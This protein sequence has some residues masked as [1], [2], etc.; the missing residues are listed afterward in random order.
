MGL[1]M[2]ERDHWESVYRSKAATEVSW[3]RPKLERSLALIASCGLGADARI[4]DVGGGASTL[5]DDLLVLGHTQLTVVDLS[6]EALEVS[7]RRL[8]GAANAV[9]WRADDVTQMSFEPG[10]IALWHDR[11]VFHFLVDE[12][13]RTAYVAQTLRAVRPGGHVLLG[14]FAPDGP[15]RCSGLP[16]VR[17]DADGLARIFEA[18]FAL[19]ASER[20]EHAT[21][22]GSTQRFVYALL[23]RRGSPGEA[24]LP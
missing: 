19:V 23:R 10:S 15:E 2:N 3:F 14:T 8:G 13:V 21:P 11:A 12:H 20:E 18:G 22:G 17:Y 9:S 24:A 6:A 5:V 7:R 4:V 16:V 1:V